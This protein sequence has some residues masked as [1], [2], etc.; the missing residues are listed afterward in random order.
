LVFGV[1][2]ISFVSFWLGFW[3][4]AFYPSLFFSNAQTHSATLFT[5]HCLSDK[6]SLRCVCL[7][8]CVCVFYRCFS[9]FCILPLGFPYACASADAYANASAYM[10][11][12]VCYP[13]TLPSHPLP[14]LP[15]FPFIL[16]SWVCHARYA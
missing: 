15:L 11:R 14:A 6:F 1:Q 5:F 3:A 8:V 4:W 12:G 9:S 7:C 16:L 13:T 2:L 10:C